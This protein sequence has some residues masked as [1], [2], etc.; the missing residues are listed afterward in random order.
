MTKTTR[1]SVWLLF[2]AMWASF[3]GNHG[4]HKLNFDEVM[5]FIVLVSSLKQPS[6]SRHALYSDFRAHQSFL[7][8]H[9]AAWLAEMQQISIL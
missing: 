3:Q 1:V 4:K 7:L 9:N 6:V 2:N 5:I 8:L